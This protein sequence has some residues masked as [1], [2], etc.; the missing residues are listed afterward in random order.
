[1][2]MLKSMPVL[3]VLAALVAPAAWAASS[4]GE[5]ACDLDLTRVSKFVDQN[6]AKLSAP[7]LRDAQR[8]LDVAKG[9]CNTEPQLGEVNLSALQRDLGMEVSQTAQ[10]PDEKQ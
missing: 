3:A 10:M 9:Q 2:T 6:R 8:R 5:V 7:A 4:G 1:M